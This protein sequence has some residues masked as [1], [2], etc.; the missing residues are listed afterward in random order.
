VKQYPP[1]QYPPFSQ[2]PIQRPKLI[3]TTSKLR[4]KEMADAAIRIEEVFHGA[5]NGQDDALMDELI[6]GLQKIRKAL[7]STFK[8]GKGLERR[9]ESYRYDMASRVPFH[10]EHI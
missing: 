10:C 7:S 1:K 8:G 4:R 2:L 6:S 5:E 9:M 3:L